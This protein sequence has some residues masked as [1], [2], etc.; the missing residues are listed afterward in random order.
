MSECRLNKIFERDYSSTGHE[1]VGVESMAMGYTGE[2]TADRFDISEDEC[3]ALALRE[4]VNVRRAI[5]EGWFKDEIVP[6]KVNGKTVDSDPLPDPLTQ[7]FIDARK[8]I[9]SGIPRRAGN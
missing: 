7:E 3:N 2:Q 9:F 8:N 6:I 1:A 4:N 5:L